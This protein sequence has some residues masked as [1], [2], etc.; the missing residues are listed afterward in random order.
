MSLAVGCSVFL[1]LFVREGKSHLTTAV[2]RQA[3]GLLLLLISNKK[4]LTIVKIL[5]YSLSS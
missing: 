3:I 5:K 4:I 1:R 2:T